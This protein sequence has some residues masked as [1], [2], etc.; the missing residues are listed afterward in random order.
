MAPYRIF[1]ILLIGASTSACQWVDST[2]TQTRNASGGGRYAPL[3]KLTEETPAQLDFSEQLPE[4]N[5]TRHWRVT[6][7]GALPSCAGSIDLD[8]ASVDLASACTSLEDNCEV[9]FIEQPDVDT[10]EVRYTVL[11]PRLSSPVGML[12]QW[13]FETAEDTITYDVTLC[14]Q[15]INE[16]PVA[17]HDR[18]VTHAK[19]TLEIA[20]IGSDED[21]NVDDVHTE[22]TPLLANDSDDRHHRGPCL[23]AELLTPPEFASND[24]TADFKHTG[25]FRY[26]AAVNGINTSDSFTYRVF[27]GEFYSE[28]ATVELIINR[29]NTQPV[30]NFDVFR[31]AGN[32]QENRLDVLDNDVNPLPQALT[33][34][35]IAVMPNQG[36][37]VL[38]EEGQSLV[39]TPAPYFYG[40][41]YF[42][43][44]IENIFGESDTT[45]MAVRV[46]PDN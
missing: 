15:A 10:G 34:T 46:R 8:K 11:P 44:T 43:Y 40:V 16:E 3:L 22:Q 36:G 1:L 7:Q 23:V 31:V 33:I 41:E 5:Y 37:S 9:V 26:A 29:E 39:Y 19:S 28:P 18:Y 30:A 38:I 27:D 12:Y 25:S 14:I 24:F 21:C 6:E 20:G 13:E 2:G 35:A 4:D 45:W 42:A 17:K 32:S